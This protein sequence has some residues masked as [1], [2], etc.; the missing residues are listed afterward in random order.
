LL[1]HTPLA[2]LVQARGDVLFFFVLSGFVLALPFFRG[3]VCYPQFVTKRVCRIYMPYYAAIALAVAGALFASRGGIP[4]LGPWFNAQWTTPITPSL[5]AQHALLI[6]SF[7]TMALDGAIWTLAHEMRISLVFPIVALLAVRCNWKACLG[8]AALLSA[9]YVGLVHFF[10]RVYGGCLASVHYTAFFVVGCLLAKHHALLTGAVARLSRPARLG[11]LSGAVMLYT[12]EFW[13]PLPQA[14]G[15]WV[16]SDWAPVAAASMFIILA[17]APGSLARF[18][19]WQPMHFIGEMSYSVYLLHIP[20]LLSVSEPVLRAHTNVEHL[21]ADHRRHPASLRDHV[22]WC[23][24]TLNQRGAL[25]CHMALPSRSCDN[26]K[27]THEGPAAML[28][29][30]QPGA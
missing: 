5:L 11:L 28:A 19:K 21:V 1:H 7:R 6:G 24:D 20:I 18:L 2:V 4:S 16:L 8:T 15:L 30:E 14:Y 22:P 25:S 27:R 17:L 12:L 13:L 26:A 10:P 23:G 3:T 9:V 29:R